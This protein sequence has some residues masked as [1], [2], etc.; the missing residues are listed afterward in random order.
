MG[1]PGGGF[2]GDGAA[3]AQD[4]R[5]DGRPVELVEHDIGANPAVTLQPEIACHY[6]RT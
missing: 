4:Q 3:P 1:G 6:Y 2:G 5:L